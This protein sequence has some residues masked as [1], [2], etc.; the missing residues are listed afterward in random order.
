MRRAIPTD[1]SPGALGGSGREGLILPFAAVLGAGFLVLLIAAAASWV[2]WRWVLLALAAATV[3]VPCGVL[4]LKGRLDVFEPL[5]WFSI[6][7]LLL[8]VG[9]PAWDLAHHNFIYTGRLI[10]PTFTRMIVAGLLGGG[11]FVIGY[12]SPAARSLVSRLPRPQPLNSRRLM[13]WS[14][15]I[16]ALAVIAFAIFFI[17]ARGW[18]DPA[19]FFFRGQKRL[20]QLSASPAATS[21]YFLASILLMVPVALFFW[22]IREREGAAVRIGRIAG[23]AALV[24]II[25]FL[26]YN[27]GA[28]QRRYVIVMVGALAVYYYLRRGRRPSG[29]ALCVTA[30]VALTLV[31]AIRDVRFAHSRNTNANP[32]QWLPWNAVTHLFKTQDTGVAP[33]LATEMLVV[34]HDLNYTYGTTTLFGPFV[35]LVPRQIWHGKPLPADQQV[36]KS[37]W[38]GTP[39]GANGQCSTFS[40]FG[41]PYRDGGLVGVFIFAVLFGVFWRSIWL[42]YVRHQDSVLAIIVCATLLPFMIS[43]MRA[44]FTLQ[45]LQATMVLTVVVLGGVLCRVRP[46]EEAGPP[47]RWRPAG[48]NG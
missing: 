39:C 48:G 1:A 43:W 9:R 26:A 32:V 29:L 22:F 31:S 4:A 46:G 38:G 20:E 21:K 8:F 16:L 42:Y 19:G 35:T 37:V 18:H 12:L 5:V 41:E 14:F 11:G 17:H 28:G 7:F 15:L 2:D 47:E 13:V 36:L 3:V 27:L 44:N 45:A 30:V 6:M 40:P 25:A 24:S 33:A 34:P 23:W 10:S